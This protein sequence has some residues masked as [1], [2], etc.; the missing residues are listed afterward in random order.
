LLNHLISGSCSVRF[1]SIRVGLRFFGIRLIVRFSIWL[2]VRLIIRVIIWLSVRLIIRVIIWLSVRL[3]IRVIIRFPVFFIIRVSI[4]I[5]IVVRF[6]VFVIFL[7][8]FIVVGFR[9][10]RMFWVIGMSKIPYWFN[11]NSLNTISN[12]YKALL[13]NGKKSPMATKWW[14]LIAGPQFW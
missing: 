10:R 1:F 3:I 13:F 5:L 7:I 12:I 9:V 8:I 11:R 4:F 2:S 6:G 14:N